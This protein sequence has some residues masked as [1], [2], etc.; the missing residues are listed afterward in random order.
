L[1]SYASRDRINRLQTA[2][3]GVEAAQAYLDRLHGQLIQVDCDAKVQ[4]EQVLD[5]L[6]VA[7]REIPMLLGDGVGPMSGVIW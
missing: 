7:Q 3:E 5:L 1:T 2:I 6:Q 4:M